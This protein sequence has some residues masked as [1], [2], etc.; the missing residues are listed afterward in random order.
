MSG[1]DY[2]EQKEQCKVGHMDAVHIKDGRCSPVNL[3]KKRENSNILFSLKKPGCVLD[4]I[5][6]Q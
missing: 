4:H 3:A 2:L 6:I 1:L 5:I